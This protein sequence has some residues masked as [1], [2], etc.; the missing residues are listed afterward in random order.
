MKVYI[1]GPYTNGDVAINVRNAILAGQQVFE[2]GHYPF[3]PH[4]THFWH[5]I[6]PAPYEQWIA[7]DLEWLP[8]CQAL[9]R[10]PGASSGADNE[11]QAALDRGISVYY[12][13]EEFIEGVK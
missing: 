1:A 8:D 4:L 11:V 3:I 2:A 12:S 10:L 7:I 5:L 13:V 6:C 9:I